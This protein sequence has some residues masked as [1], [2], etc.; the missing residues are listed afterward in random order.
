MRRN[1]NASP[2]W[3]VSHTHQEV[4]LLV[5][6]KRFLR[7]GWSLGIALLLSIGIIARLGFAESPAAPDDEV[8]PMTNQLPSEAPGP[9]PAPAQIPGPTTGAQPAA[10]TSVTGTVTY[11][12]RM[13]L[14]ANAVVQVSLQDIS[15]A[16]AP[17]V[18]LGEQT[19]E[20]GGRQVPIPFAIPYDAATIDQ[21][22]TY[23][24]RARITVDGQ[25]M[26]TSTTA[27]LVITR[28]HPTDVEIVVQRV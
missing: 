16:D 9:Q 27:N 19:I 28:G 14:P 4:A 23:A 21:R 7:V 11:R 6:A 2:S 3:T 15:R 22:M 10:G 26:F 18:V 20:T 5:F 25:L 24:V 12:E 13:A 17:A 1:W 8:V